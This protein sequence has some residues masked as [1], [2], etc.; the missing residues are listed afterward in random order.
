MRETTEQPRARSNDLVVKPVGEEVLVYDL[1]RHRAHSLNRVAAAVWQACDG[2][3]GTAALAAEATKQ[4]GQIVPVEAVRYALQG[5]GKAQL[6]EGPV[7]D[8]RLTRREV[9]AKLGTAAAIAL[10]LVTTITT[11]TAAQTA[12]CKA[13]NTPCTTTA[14]CCGFGCGP[15][16]SGCTCT[17]FKT[18]GTFCLRLE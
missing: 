3:R 2:A 1:A 4:S 7:A 17:F 14:E 8:S 9:M 12:S 10:P 16:T 13:V 15:T 5:L 18:F 6:L 11:P